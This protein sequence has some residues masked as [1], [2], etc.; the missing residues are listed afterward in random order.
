M[1]PAAI[2]LDFIARQGRLSLAGLLLL[3]CGIGAA[4]WTYADYR[5][6]LLESDLLDIGLSRYE[7]RGVDSAATP[8]PR[9]QQQVQVAIGTL[10]TPWSALLND[11]EQAAADSGDEVAL[12]QVVPD[13]SKRQVRIAAEART[14]PAALAYVKRL[15]QTATLRFPMLEA[16]EVRTADRNRPVRFEVSAEWSLEP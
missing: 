8:D 14:L 12:L 13:R 2:D 16:H 1:T 7:D 15:Q 6:T 4:W 5:D 11:L 3:F 10:S 9:A